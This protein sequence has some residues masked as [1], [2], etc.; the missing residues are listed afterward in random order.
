MIFHYDFN[1]DDYS[2]YRRGFV[3]LPPY[4]K[5]VFTD[6]TS[7]EEDPSTSKTEDAEYQIV[8]SCLKNS[9][10]ILPAQKSATSK[11]V[12]TPTPKEAL[13]EFIKNKDKKNRWTSPVVTAEDIPCE[14]VNGPGCFN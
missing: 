10:T 11:I 4:H 12:S 7:S 5:A 1:I 3:Q 6:D 14:I 9:E 8:S 2:P 13:A